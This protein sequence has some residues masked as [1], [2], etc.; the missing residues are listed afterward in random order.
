MPIYGGSGWSC[1][2]YGVLEEWLQS[3]P[4]GCLRGRREMGTSA[5]SVIF[6]HSD[7]QNLAQFFSKR[8]DF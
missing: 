7:T 5:A 2:L 8:D 6:N 3:I 1:P 4:F